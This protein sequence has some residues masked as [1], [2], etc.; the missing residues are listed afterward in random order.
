[1][2]ICPLILKKPLSVSTVESPGCNVSF[3][4]IN[5]FQICTMFYHY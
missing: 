1:M 3:Q 4:L 2:C 5:P